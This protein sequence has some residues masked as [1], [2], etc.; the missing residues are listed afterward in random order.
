[1]PSA[2]NS[3]TG[4]AEMQ[5]FERGG[6]SAAPFSSSVSER[7]RWM[8]QMWSC[9]VDGDAADLAEDPVVRQR[10]WPG[11]VDREGRD[12]AGVRRD[13]AC[14]M[15]MATAKQVEMA[16][17]RFW[18]ARCTR[19]RHGGLPMF[20]LAGCPAW[21]QSIVERGRVNR[22]ARH[23][24]RAQRAKQSGPSLVV[25]AGLLR[26]PLA[27]HA[28]DRELTPARG[29]SSACA[30]CSHT[31]CRSRSIGAH[32]GTM[33]SA[34]CSGVS[35]VIGSSPGNT[36]ARMRV[37][38]G[39][40]LNRLTRSGVVLTVSLAQDAHQRVQRGLRGRV[41]ALIGVGLAGAPEVTN[42]ARPASETL[43]Q[44]VHAADQLEVRGDVDRHHVVPRL[45][46]DMAER[47]RRAGDAGIADQNVE[48]A[49]T[50]MQRARR[51]GRCRRNR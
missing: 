45:Q 32:I 36:L 20:F 14:A 8:T 42:T 13:A 24:E 16:L 27:M 38:I 43:Q 21:R 9:V 26:L 17:Q 12:V 50:L 30:S 51:A 15:S 19:R 39:P 31:A 28:P 46:L 40:G 10:F 23:R 11:R 2:S 29:N 44:R 5:H 3:S 35:S 47:R 48:L 6:L 25:G 34:A 33:N 4:G 49:V 18:R 7:G 41:G 22:V 37:R 1:M